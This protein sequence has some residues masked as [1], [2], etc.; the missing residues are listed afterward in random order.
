[1]RDLLICDR[2]KASLDDRVLRYNLA[3]E[4][5]SEK[6]WLPSKE[7][8]VAI[9]TY[10]ANHIGERPLSGVLTAPKR[11]N[12]DPPKQ[13]LYLP[14]SPVN[15]NTSSGC[16]VCGSKAHMKRDCPNKNTQKYPSAQNGR[17]TSFKANRCVTDARNDRV[18]VGS[19]SGLADSCC[20]AWQQSTPSPI[21]TSD[22][23]DSCRV[24]DYHNDVCDTV[25]TSQASDDANNVLDLTCK[26]SSEQ[27]NVKTEHL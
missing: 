23:V 13:N 7:L 4:A 21:L 6:G 24:D 20:S 5:K 9:D 26:P 25:V 1:L 16:F 27:F 18:E 12:F 2:I 22:V 15:K 17:P 3:V 10:L 11:S 19:G 14:K 8:T